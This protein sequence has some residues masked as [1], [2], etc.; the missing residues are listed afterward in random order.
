MFSEIDKMKYIDIA[1]II[2]TY[3]KAKNMLSNRKEV[4]LTEEQVSK[5]KLIQTFQKAEREA[6]IYHIKCIAMEIKSLDIK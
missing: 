4:Y 1:E 5:N 2:Y 3:K 6:F